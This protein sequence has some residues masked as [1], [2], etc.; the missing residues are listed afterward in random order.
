[1]KLLKSFRSLMM[2]LFL[3]LK[4]DEK[5]KD[6]PTLT[7]Q[8]PLNLQFFSE[9]PEDPGGG[10]DDKP[11]VSFKT[12]EE[13]KAKISEGQLELAKSLGYESVEAMEKAVK[14]VKGNDYNKNDNNKKNDKNEKKKED[15]PVDVD[16][17]VE[18]KLAAERE[19]T[20][21]R[22]K[23]AEVKAQAKDLKFLDWEEAL[24]LADLSEVKEDEKGNIVGVKEALEALATKKPH[25]LEGKSGKFGADIPHSSQ[26][27]NKK[28]NL[29]NIKKQ[30]ASRGIHKT[31]AH[32]PWA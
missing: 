32:N 15:E 24:L 8:L 21:E 11:F 5:Q 28:E 13:L 27:N 20:F 18:Q 19:K 22:L 7:K 17:I 30:A 4:R 16:A 26:N 10:G 29:E 2:T 1:M 3:F 6:L 9:N 14:A 31:A 12:E 23:N 25:L